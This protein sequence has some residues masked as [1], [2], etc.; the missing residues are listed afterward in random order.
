MNI[1]LDNL[2]INQLSTNTDDQVSFYDSMKIKN[3]NKIKNKQNIKGGDNSMNIDTIS[4]VKTNP[5][6]GFPPIYLIDKDTITDNN[7]SKKLRSLSNNL[8]K[9]RSLSIKT[10]LEN[11]ALNRNKKN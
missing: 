3:T 11:R 7:D 9:K 6:G 8:N 2:M 5:T 10:I 4:S 1:K